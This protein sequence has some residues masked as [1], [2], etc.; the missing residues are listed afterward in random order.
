MVLSMRNRTRE[1]D[2]RLFFKLSLHVLLQRYGPTWAYYIE[3]LAM[4]ID[5]IQ[6]Q[7]AMNLSQEEVF[8]HSTKS[9]TR[10]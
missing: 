4:N 6:F 1:I 3:R 9:K 2:G 7:S 5:F 10:Y 8:L